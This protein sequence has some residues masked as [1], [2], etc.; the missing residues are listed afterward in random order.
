MILS[1]RSEATPILTTVLLA[2]TFT[3]GKLAIPALI[4]FAARAVPPQRSAHRWLLRRRVHHR[5]A[6]ERLLKHAI[7]RVR[8]HGVSPLLTA[9]EDSPILRP[10]PCSP[11]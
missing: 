10:T 1:L 7:Y 2:V 6:A 4:L 8:P 11:W 5:R 3:S 9:A